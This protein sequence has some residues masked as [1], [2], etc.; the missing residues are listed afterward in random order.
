M[1]Q[2]ANCASHFQPRLMPNREKRPF[3]LWSR[4]NMLIRVVII[5]CNLQPLGYS[6][7]WH[8]G[9]TEREQQD[10]IPHRNRMETRPAVSGLLRYCHQQFHFLTYYFCHC[11]KIWRAFDKLC[12]QI[13]QKRKCQSCFGK[14]TTNIRLCFNKDRNQRL[15][16]KP[17]DFALKGYLSSGIKQNS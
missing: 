9:N 14:C 17:D 16:S 7:T 2:R 3:S 13:A 10:S 12:L 4:R 15:F 1:V 6:G 11:H 8:F 5:P